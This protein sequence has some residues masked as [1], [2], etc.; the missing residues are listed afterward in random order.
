MKPSPLAQKGNS[1][2]SLWIGKGESMP[3]LGRLYPLVFRSGEA[4]PPDH[5]S[6][7]I[8][9]ILKP[10]PL[11]TQA[12]K[13][14]CWTTSWTGGGDQRPHSGL[15]YNHHT[16]WGSQ[17]LL[18]AKCQALQIPGKQDSCPQSHAM[19]EEG[20]WLLH[21]MVRALVA[22]LSPEG[23]LG[24]GEGVAAQTERVKA[25]AVWIHALSAQHC[26]YWQLPTLC[27]VWGVKNRELS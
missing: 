8:R 10:A 19:Q 12:Q 23:Q 18:S 11:D 17:S 7:S 21:R 20:S 15:Q 14:L 6:G 22:E 25:V 24:M 27:D 4:W 16:H 5:H 1:S 3:P 13:E 9:S 26:T 2:R